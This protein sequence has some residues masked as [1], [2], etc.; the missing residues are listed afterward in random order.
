MRYR[1]RNLPLSQYPFFHIYM[2]F[3]KSHTLLQFIV[4]PQN[5]AFTANTCFIE[6]TP[7]YH[8]SL[9][10]RNRR[11]PMYH[12]PFSLYRNRKGEGSKPLPL[13]RHDIAI[14]PSTIQL[15]PPIQRF[16]FI[17]I[18]ITHRYISP[19][20]ISLSL[21]ANNTY[22]IYY[23]PLLPRRCDIAT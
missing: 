8:K 1:Y 12:K 21:N 3:R 7:F 19:D 22:L 10:Y 17:R 16:I 14:T 2:F 5:L 11:I 13:R 23:D 6:K 20:A 15:T 18:T 4:F 9:L